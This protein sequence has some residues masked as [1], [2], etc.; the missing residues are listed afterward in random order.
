LPPILAIVAEIANPVSEQTVLKRLENMEN[1]EAIAP[2]ANAAAKVCLLI[3]TWISVTSGISSVIIDEA[4]IYWA[5]GGISVWT[6]VWGLFGIRFFTDVAYYKVANYF[7]EVPLL[8]IR[9]A[10]LVSFTI[11]VM[12][13]LVIAIIIS[14]WSRIPSQ[15]WAATNISAKPPPTMDDLASLI[16]DN[17]DVA[18][19]AR[20]QSDKARS[21]AVQAAAAAASADATAKQ[22]LE[23]AGS[24][25]RALRDLPGQVSN[26]L[27]Q[28]NIL[29]ARTDRS[30][31]RDQWRNIQ[32]RL[33][34][35][36]I[37]VKVNGTKGP[38]TCSAIRLYQRQ[39]GDDDTGTLTPG[40]ILT[41]LDSVTKTLNIRLVDNI[42]CR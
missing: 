19:S 30:L 31:N 13:F 8:S 16:K 22:I 12:N 7:S 2:I 14:A 11:I 10:H 29:Q 17:A 38:N 34:A 33:A 18:E 27:S 28:L 35:K 25:Q 39:L 26:V 23:K 36:G 9:R 40:E 1:A 3:P 15:F 21:A 24:L 4:N 20:T 6:I 41:L 42:A 32:E 37:K 5:L